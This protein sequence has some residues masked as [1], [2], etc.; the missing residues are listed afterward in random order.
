MLRDIARRGSFQPDDMRFLETPFFYWGRN[1]SGLVYGWACMSGA[2]SRRAV[3]R[4]V[5]VFAPMVCAFWLTPLSQWVEKVPGLVYGLGVLAKAMT[6]ALT[7][8]MDTARVM[9]LFLFT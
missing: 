9:S 1:V 5:A 4:G 6:M 7:M 8:A 2:M 3:S